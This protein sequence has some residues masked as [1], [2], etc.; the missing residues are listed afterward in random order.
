[1]CV[2]DPQVP[3]PHP[4]PP[5]PGMVQEVELVPGGR[6]IAVTFASRLRYVEAAEAH[7]LHECD[8]QLAA[9]RRGLANVVPIR[10]LSL[11]TWQECE[12]LVAGSPVIDLELLKRHTRYEAYSATD[13]VIERFWKVM[14]SFTDQ[15]RS[16]YVR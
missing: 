13:P 9:L 16:D 11:F 14:E 10:A 3:S 12:V 6:D 15:Q 4:A 7:R 8:V 5:R 1:L 2:R